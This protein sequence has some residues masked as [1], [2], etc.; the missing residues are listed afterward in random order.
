M[1]A[2]LFDDHVLLVL[3]VLPGQKPADKLLEDYR[4]SS[5]LQKPPT[6]NPHVDDCISHIIQEE[7][8]GGEGEKKKEQEKQCAFEQQ[9]NKSLYYIRSSLS[10]F[11]R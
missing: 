2:Y 11:R 3:D 1:S 7:E 6:Y 8:E 4:G 5:R 9:G 10:F